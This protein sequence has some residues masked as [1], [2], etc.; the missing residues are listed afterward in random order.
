MDKD[1]RKNRKMLEIAKGNSRWQ[2]EF[3]IGCSSPVSFGSQT[4]LHE[5][6]IRDR[7]LGVRKVSDEIK[8]IFYSAT[9]DVIR[10]IGKI[11][12]DVESEGWVVKQAEFYII[13]GG[14]RVIIENNI[15]PSLGIG[16]RQKRVEASISEVIT[17]G[18]LTPVGD[19]S[20]IQC[21]YNN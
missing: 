13:G 5:L 15:L 8:N 20:L 4:K 2:T 3:Q 12:V 6:K 14:Q 10:I 21:K 7:F 1:G 19:Y 9:E 17:N 18:T 11:L 16:V